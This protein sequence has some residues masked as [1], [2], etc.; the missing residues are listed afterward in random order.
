VIF[1]P[2]RLVEVGVGENAAPPVFRPSCATSPRRILRF[3][4]EV[5]VGEDL[6]VL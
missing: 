2:D 6:M 4:G 3:S 5:I 1:Y